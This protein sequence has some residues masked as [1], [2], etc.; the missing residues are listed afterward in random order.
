MLQQMRSM[1]MYIFWFVAI[2]FLVG[3]VFFGGMDTGNFGGPGANVV[4]RINGRDIPYEV[5]SR[6][7]SQMADL[8]RSRF[9]R[10]ELLPQ[11]YER[12]EAQAWNNLVDELIVTQEARRLGI[13]VADDEIADILTSAPPDFIR[14]RFTSESGE[15]DVAAYQKAL[16]DPN[17]NWLQEENYIRAILP[18]FKLQQMVRAQA[19]VS[20]VEVRTEWARRNQRA[21][22]EYAGVPWSDVTLEG[23]APTE[24]D[25]RAYYD[26]H[27]ERFL[28]GETA[29]L[30]VVRLDK[31]PSA[32]D[33][34]DLMEEARDALSQKNETFATLAE[35][36]SDDPSAPR[37]GDIGWVTPE[38]LPQPV[39]P[40][41]TA[42]APGQTSDILRAEQGLYIVHV[43]S[44]RT[45]A[46]GREMR[47]RQIF[48]RSKPSEETLDSLRTRFL[49]VADKAREDFAGAAREL[50]VEVQK[51][52]PIENIGFIPGIGFS[53]RLVDWAFE[54]APGEVSEPVGTESAFVVARLVEKRPQEPRPFESV[55]DQARYFLEESRKKERARARVERLLAAVRGGKSFADAARSE[56]LEAKQPAPFAYFEAVAGIGSANEFSLVAA[57]L[58][59]G[60]TSGV[61]ETASGAYVLRVLA[62]DAFDEAAY[63]ADRNNQYQSLLTR[64]QGE[65]YE[66]WLKKLRES[67]EI[68]DRRPPRV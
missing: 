16:N 59:A 67:A 53:K 18:T 30:E 12:I 50:G 7:V 6:A 42:L 3:F 68:Q 19:T 28:R 43:D 20:E 44:V 35:I 45:V 47:L 46:T 61:I 17:V 5:Y 13:R 1:K 65:V 9:Q 37:G 52:E 60:G 54:A 33:D 51:L 21:T 25:L 4:G 55:Q 15:F 2:T 10:D 29:T 56:G 14:Q 23:F 32:T 57:T 36:Y 62:R 41:A 64:R 26:Q 39:G 24:G 48:M 34:A 22:V 11:D 40:A 58:D 66:A 31:K 49:E 63:A 38:Q 8:E 27:P